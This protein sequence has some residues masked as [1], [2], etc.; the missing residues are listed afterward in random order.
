MYISRGAKKRILLPDDIYKNLKAK[1]ADEG[2]Y[3][4]LV[5]SEAEEFVFRAIDS[6]SLLRFLHPTEELPIP[7]RTFAHVWALPSREALRWKK[8]SPTEFMKSRVVRDRVEAK[9]GKGIHD[10]PELY[11]KYAKDERVAVMEDFKR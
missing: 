11:E 8:P 9:H 7:R 2:T 4:S 5:F 10:N 1:I 3:D 6:C